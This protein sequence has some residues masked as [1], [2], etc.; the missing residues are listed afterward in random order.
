MTGM[1]VLFDMLAILSVAIWLVKLAA[2]HTISIEAAATILLVLVALRVAGR[3]RRVSLVRQIFGIG[4]PL[5][6][7][8]TFTRSSTSGDPRAMAELYY[9]FAVLIVVLFGYYVMF[10]G[11]FS[12]R[13]SRH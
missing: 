4:L 1:G 9:L 8:Y 2:E 11:A 6:S 3:A 7:L 12:G 5:A 10:F 13:R